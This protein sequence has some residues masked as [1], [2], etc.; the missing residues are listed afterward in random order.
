[1]YFKRQR[2]VPSTSFTKDH[3]I[4][5]HYYRSDLN[6][7]EYNRYDII[8]YCRWLQVF[9][10]RAHEY[11]GGLSDEEHVDSVVHQGDDPG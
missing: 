4:I 9:G 6:T 3:S 10:G 7:V 2:Y 5:R 11:F 8:D 1:M